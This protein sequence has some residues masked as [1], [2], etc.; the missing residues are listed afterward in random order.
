MLRSFSLH[1]ALRRWGHRMVSE[2]GPRQLGGGQRS[3]QVKST[4]MRVGKLSKVKITFGDFRERGGDEC[5]KSLTRFPSS[6]ANWRAFSSRFFGVEQ[7]SP[8]FRR[9]PTRT[10]FAKQNR[11]EGA[12]GD[13]PPSEAQEKKPPTGRFF[14]MLWW[15]RRES[16]PRPK[17]LYRQFYIL[18]TA[19]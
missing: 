4:M 13:D 6:R 17:A 8:N 3:P 7:C 11:P 5:K 10:G 2:V 14:R 15:R 1:G 9:T 12:P 19:I 18:S 16:N